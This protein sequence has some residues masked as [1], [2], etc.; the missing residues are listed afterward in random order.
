MG[1]KII[2]GNAELWHGDMREIMP[3]LGECADM[4]FSDVP[5]KLTSGGQQ[6]PGSITEWQLAEGYI[7]DGTIID[8]DIEFSEFMPL[9]YKAMRGDSHAYIMVNN[10]NVKEM[11]VEAEKGKLKFHNLLV[12]N[13]ITCTPNRFFA[14]NCEFIGLFFKGKAKYINNM[15]AKQL[16]TVDQENYSSHPTSKPVALCEYYIRQSTKEDETVLDPFMGAGS[17]AIAALKSGRKFIGC[18]IN[19]RW[20]NASVKRITDFYEQP[21]QIQMI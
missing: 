21:Q 20:F 19:E 11:L 15:S 1:N 13:K 12:W 8:C 6:K 7:N 4:I 17:T 5:Y 10:R 14:K 9:F 16:I 3:L 18:E 2:I